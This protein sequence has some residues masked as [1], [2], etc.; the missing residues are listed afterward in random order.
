DWSV[1]TA[2]ADLVDRRVE[3]TGPVERKMA[4]NALNSGAMVWLAD[5]EDAN[6]PHWDNV[7]GGQLTLR[8]A[9]RRRLS[10]T[11]PEGKAYRLR[12]DGP[13]AV[14]VVRPR[15]W[16]LDEHHLLLDNKPVVAALADFGLHFFHNAAE[17]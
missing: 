10:F 3:I 13:L 9:V 5:L 4:I 17:L 1:A 16:H 12:E 14:L 15:G 2:P 6:T 11:S 7:V 8:D